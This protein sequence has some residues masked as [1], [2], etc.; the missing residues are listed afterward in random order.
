MSKFKSDKQRKAMFASMNK[1]TSK[2]DKFQKRMKE[3]REKKETK[4]SDFKRFKDEEEPNVKYWFEGKNGEI[5]SCVSSDERHNA[6]LRV[7]GNDFDSFSVPMSD[8]KYETISE[9]EEVYSI[10]T[11]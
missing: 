4:Q 9:E 6:E 5:I 3:Q 10:L 2:T 8:D 1:P 11:K 7:S